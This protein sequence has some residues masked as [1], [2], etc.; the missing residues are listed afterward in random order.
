M[1]PLHKVPQG[2]LGLLRARTLGRNPDELASVVSTIVNA[3]PHY[4][5]DLQVTAQ[6]VSGAGAI[7]Q[8]LTGTATFPGRLIAM[9]GFVTVGAA[10][11]T[12]L[13][14]AFVY[15]PS[16]QFANQPVCLGSGSYA[17]PILAAGVQLQFG[18]TLPEPIVFGPGSTFTLFTV[19]DAGGADHNTGR[20]DLFENYAP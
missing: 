5:S 14:W 4:G 18:I 12:R 3:T 19:G 15:S 6:T 10:A 20:R 17:A 2:L 9:G 13:T 11:G 16:P 7:S 1:I 8:T